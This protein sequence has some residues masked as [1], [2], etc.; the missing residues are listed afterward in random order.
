MRLKE[1]S[2]CWATMAR[3]RHNRGSAKHH[4]I[5]HEL[6]VVF[7]YGSGRSLETRIG[8]ITRI[9]PF[10]TQAPTELFIRGFPFELGR[11]SHSLPF[12]EC[13]CFIKRHVSDRYVG[14][15]LL[16]TTEREIQQ[17]AIPLYPVERTLDV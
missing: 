15:K 5:D 14:P 12:G 8:K 13:R 9:R 10:P 6:A 17:L 7:P 3:R 11:Q 16:Q 2:V 1:V 4:L